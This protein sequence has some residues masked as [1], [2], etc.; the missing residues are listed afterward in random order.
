MGQGESTREAL[1]QSDFQALYLLSF[2]SPGDRFL[3]GAEIFFIYLQQKL[4]F[5]ALGEQFCYTGER[6]INILFPTLYFKDPHKF[7]G[8]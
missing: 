1:R 8:E 5:L 3:L 6:S 7:N 4:K 2:L